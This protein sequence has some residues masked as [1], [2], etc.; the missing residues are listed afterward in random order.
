MPRPLWDRVRKWEESWGPINRAVRRK[1]TYETQLGKRKKESMVLGGERREE[2]VPSGGQ[3]A[4]RWEE[5]TLASK[6]GCYII[7]S[8]GAKKKS[9]LLRG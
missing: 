9:S 6:Q 1:D 8:G 3:K 4:R 5:G 2:G 7:S